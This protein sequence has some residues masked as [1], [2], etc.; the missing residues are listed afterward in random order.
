M[1]TTLSATASRTSATTGAAGFPDSSR[2]DGVALWSLRA[3][4][5]GQGALGVA[6]LIAG[7]AGSS[8][9]AAPVALAVLGA[10][11]LLLGVAT[12]TR[13]RPVV[14][15]ASIGTLAVLADS[16]LTVAGVGMLLLTWAELSTG[17]AGTLLVG[18]VVAV[19]AAIA[20]AFAGTDDRA[21]K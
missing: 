18:I 14:D 1:T 4:G 12:A 6:L 7:I 20:T 11:F 15:H 2:R 8:T 21:A 5:A 3:V 9:G 19:A 10:A 16:A 13:P 17:G